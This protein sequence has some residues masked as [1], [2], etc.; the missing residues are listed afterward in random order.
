MGDFWPKKRSSVAG[1]FGLVVGVMET[2]ANGRKPA[3]NHVKPKGKVYLSDKT[4]D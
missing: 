3:A 4:Y 1:R 2:A